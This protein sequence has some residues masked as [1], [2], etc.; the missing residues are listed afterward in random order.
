MLGLGILLAPLVARGEQARSGAD[1]FW[2]H[3][4]FALVMALCATLSGLIILVFPTQFKA[5]VYDLIRP[6]LPWCGGGLLGSGLMLG[7]VHLTHPRSRVVLWVV[8]IIVAGAFLPFLTVAVVNHLWTG[9]AFYGGLGLTLAMLPW[10]GPH[11]RLVDS[12]ALQTRLALVLVVLVA[13]PLITTVAVG[14]AS[15]ERQAIS[16]AIARQ[17]NLASVLA[18]DVA[19]YV[20]LHRAPIAGLAAYPDLTTLPATRQRTILE[21][22]DKA[23][24]DV[25]S[26]ASFDAAGAGLARSDGG[27]PAPAKGAPVYEQARQTNQPALDIRISS[28]IHRPIFAFGEPIRDTQGH[29]AGLVTG[30]L[31]ATRLADVLMRAGTETR[32]IAYLVDRAGR[33]IA[34]PDDHLVSSFASLVDLPPVAAFTH[35]PRFGV[36]RY[37]AG[38]DE[39]LAAY[40]LVPGF[41]WG[42]IVERPMTDIL[43]GVRAV[44]EQA[45]GVLLLLTVLTSLLGAWISRRLAAPLQMLTHALADFAAGKGTTPLPSSTFSE[46]ADLASGF[47]AMR[48]QIESR[49]REREQVEAMLRNRERQLAKAQTIAHVGSWEWDIASNRMAWSEELYRIY[50]LQSDG[51]TLHYD[52]FLQRVHPKDRDRVHASLTE[53]LQNHQP[54]HFEHRIIL[55]DGTI[56]F[57]QA[58]GEAEFDPAGQPIRLVGTG[59]DI[60]ELKQIEEALTRQTAELQRSN[61][62]LEQFAYVASHD[63]QEPLR[64]VA[65]YVQLLAQRYQGQLDTKADQYIA[66]AVDGATR[67][68]AL[69]NDLLAFSRV[70]LQEQELVLIQS[71]Q[72]LAHAQANLSATIAE[73]H[74]SVTHDPLPSVRGNA[75]LLTQLFQNLIGNA[76]KFHGAD[77]PRVHISVARHAT[78]WVFS[79][80]DNGIGIDP[81]H[82]ARIFL[83]FQ[84]LHTRT[85]YVGT[86]IGLALC[87]KIVEYQHGRIWVE[88]ELGHGTRFFFTLRAGE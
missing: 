44:R 88:S 1:P 19:T 61:A 69:I 46:V 40:A 24:P 82:F 42:V 26:F 75:G 59:Q 38:A 71:E 83:I 81:K 10:L 55:P 53:A 47:A 68:Q 39:A 33:A 37:R 2:S 52:V 79:V 64:M 20:S 6:G 63:L 21:A 48:Q 58:T 80:E 54:F 43:I 18:Q 77:P 28:R 17:Q 22:F 74:A 31:E 45:F 12:A 7:V 4:L 86:G 73:Q 67:M 84:R 16:E 56:R 51:G 57:Q 32:G 60:T 62:E 23:Y 49:T 70:N 5:P 85:K 66:Y 14:T 72:S 3:D 15:Y 29:F 25:V 35:D 30:V 65:S 76:I 36:L 8:H 41:G 27:P 34:H 78:E 50:G 11:L 13:L 9:I 87:K